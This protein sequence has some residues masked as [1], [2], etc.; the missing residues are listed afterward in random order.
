[1]LG[2]DVTGYRSAKRGP[3]A[4]RVKKFLGLDLV[5]PGVNLQESC[6]VVCAAR[7]GED[8]DSVG[9]VK[10]RASPAVI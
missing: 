7:V 2:H 8:Y 3:A 9:L 10:L 6:D 5:K 4:A 1:M